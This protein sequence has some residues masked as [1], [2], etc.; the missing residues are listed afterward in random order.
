MGTSGDSGASSP[1]DHATERTWEVLIVGSGFSGQSAL[2]RLRKAGIDDVLILERRDFLGGT[3][4][5]NTYPGAA[6][7]VHSPLYSIS[8]EP[9]P[10]SQMFA[11]RDEL[12][13]YTDHVI[14]K[15]RMRERT[16]LGA[17][18]ESF[19]WSDA[20]RVWTVRAR[21]GRAFRARYVIVATGPL[22]TPKIPEFAGRASFRGRAFHSNAWDHSFD[23]RGKRVA[24]IGSGASA[25]QIIPAIAPEVAA[26]HV[27]QRTPHWV[28]PRPDRAFSPIERRLLRNRHVYGALR[29]AIYLG[30]ETRVIGFKYSRS[31]LDRVAQ[32]RALRHIEQQIP[33][34]ALRRKVTPR[35]VIGCKRVIVSSTLYPALTRKNVTLHDADDAVAELV[36]DGI[37]TKQGAHVALDAIVWATGY[38]ATDGVTTFDVTGRGG[39]KLGDFWGEYPRAYLGTAMPGFPNLFLMLGPNTGIGHTSALFIMESQLMYVMRCIAAARARGAR[40]IEPTRAA[41]RAWTEWVHREME[42]TV[43]AS[44]GCDSWYKNSRTGKVIAMYPGFSFTYRWRAVRFRPGEHLFD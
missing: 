29:A 39:A 23:V 17:D 10:W 20:E 27:F 36:P 2:I 24:V 9:Y 13:A 42:G 22:S 14:A 31:L 18:V 41:E 1:V 25:A 30:L 43:W 34:P 19:T 5:Q 37:R 38:D 6:V 7:D 3:W 35:F 16:V 8:S 11:G 4:C 33:D 28:M 15:H 12:H 44:G 26:L 32:R 21:D 40:A